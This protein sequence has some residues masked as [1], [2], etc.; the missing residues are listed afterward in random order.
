[1]V[2]AKTHRKELK[3]HHQLISIN[4]VDNMN[5]NE[6]INLPIILRS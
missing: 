3:F 1:V 5:R 6:Y 2:A 4:E